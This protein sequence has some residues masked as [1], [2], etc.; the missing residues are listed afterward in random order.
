[1]KYTGLLRLCFALVAFA[2]LFNGSESQ[3]KKYD[4]YARE[5]Y[6]AQ[7]NTDFIPPEATIQAQTPANA[8]PGTANAAPTKEA[9]AGAEVKKKDPIAV[10]ETNKGVIYIRLFQKYAPKTV[11]HFVMLVNKGFYNGLTFHRHEKGFVI[12]G[13]CPQGNGMG[14]YIDPVTNKP[15]YIDLEVNSKLRH[16]SAGVVA[17][18][19]R[20]DNINSNSCQFYITLAAQPSLN[21]KYTVFGGV[22]SGMEVVHSL[23]KGDKI[24]SM[25]IQQR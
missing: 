15:K 11:D 19:R 4:I 17:M 25:K 14:D 9:A 1:M 3:A 23:T 24:V 13:G 22:L 12:Q 20:G 16:N 2:L 8:H 6:L 7:K 21:D 5:K 10:L 18:A